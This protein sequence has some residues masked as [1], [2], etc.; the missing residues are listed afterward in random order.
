LR[1]KYLEFFSGLKNPSPTEPS[2]RSAAPP[3]L[4]LPAAS[5]SARD[6]PGRIG[7]SGGEMAEERPDASRP[8][9]V[10]WRIGCVECRSAEIQAAENLERVCC[11]LRGRFSFRFRRV[12]R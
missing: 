5:G 8:A 12:T 11:W 6:G 10:P 4:P 1:N 7:E 2:R 3:I 9:I